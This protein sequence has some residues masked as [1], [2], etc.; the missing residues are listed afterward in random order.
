MRQDLVIVKIKLVG[1]PLV[2]QML[3]KEATNQEIKAV[4]QL[5]SCGI[6]QIEWYSTCELLQEVER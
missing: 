1:F 2:V 5:E 6:V 4:E 3:G